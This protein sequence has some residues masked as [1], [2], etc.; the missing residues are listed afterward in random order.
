MDRPGFDLIAFD[1]DDTLWHNERS[2]R[3]ARERFRRLL[4]S[5]GV[6]LSDDEIEACVNRTELENI[7]YYGY[8]VSSFTLSLIETAI[9]LTGGRVGGSD[10]AGLIELA[11]EMLSEE[12]ELFESA[13]GALA[14][15]SATHPLMLITKGDLLHQ[16]SKLERSGLQPFFKYVEVVSHKTPRVYASILARHGVDPERF[17]MIGNSLRSDVLPVIEIGARAVH[18]PAALSWAHEHADVP[19]EAKDRF[20]ELP[21][22]ESLA[23]LVASLESPASSSSARK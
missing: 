4:S 11:K 20:I 14:A 1:G 7:D 16:T 5:A 22:L 2:Y 10:L 21:S 9:D 18:V 3:H 6:D 12:I 15:L 19:E 13:R 23:E 17:L 8:G